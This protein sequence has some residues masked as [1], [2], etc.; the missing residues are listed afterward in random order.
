MQIRKTKPIKS[1][2]HIVEE[3]LIAMDKIDARNAINFN[4]KKIYIE[5]YYIN[6]SISKHNNNLLISKKRNNIQSIRL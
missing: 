6:E 5:I 2:R 1:N 4:N 3:A